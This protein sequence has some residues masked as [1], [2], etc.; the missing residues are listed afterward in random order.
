VC[1]KKIEPSIFLFRKTLLLQLCLFLL[2]LLS[3]NLRNQPIPRNSS[4]D[5]N[6][7][8]T[9]ALRKDFLFL[10]VMIFLFVVFS[11][12]TISGAVTWTTP[13]QQHVV[14]GS[15]L[16]LMGTAAGDF[17]V[18]VPS[19]WILKLIGNWLSWLEVDAFVPSAQQLVGRP[20]IGNLGIGRG[21]NRGTTQQRL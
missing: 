16:L 17:M 12:L 18:L 13:R 4:N 14:A 11:H 5:T 20:R 21:D 19:Y 1:F 6:V 9:S 8:E 3:C 15:L 10:L 2:L 7:L